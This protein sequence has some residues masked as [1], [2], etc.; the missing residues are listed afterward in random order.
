MHQYD[1]GATAL[2]KVV[3]ANV[4][5]LRELSN[6]WQIL[7]RFF[8]GKTGKENQAQNAHGQQKQNPKGRH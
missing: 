6:R 1:G 3:K 2:V 4:A 7:F 8:I 5:Q